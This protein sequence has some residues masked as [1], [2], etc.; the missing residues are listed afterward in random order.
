MEGKV[1]NDILKKQKQLSRKRPKNLNIYR[2]T[3]RDNGLHRFFC[4]LL[5]FPF[6]QR[7]YG[8]TEGI[9]ILFKNKTSPYPSPNLGE[10][11]HA[12]MGEVHH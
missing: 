7:E 4:V 2:E 12:V 3:H 5:M 10:G 11:N 1:N 8:E 9:F 6:N